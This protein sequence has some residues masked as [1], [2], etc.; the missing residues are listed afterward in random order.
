MLLT[1]P[2]FLQACK[3]DTVAEPAVKEYPGVDT[4]LWKYFERFEQEG[5]RRGFE[6]D[7]ISRGISATIE[8]IAQE[9]VGGLCNYFSNDAN[10]LVIDDYIWENTSELQKEL[11]IFHELGHCYLFRDHRDDAYDDGFCKSLMRS[12]TNDCV[13]HY[14]STTRSL[15]LG[16]LFDPDSVE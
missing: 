14:N 16:E 10:E 5:E 1:I 6:I 12:G 7:L 4:A 11:I 3:K 15:Y 8:P 9:H 13:D 2:L